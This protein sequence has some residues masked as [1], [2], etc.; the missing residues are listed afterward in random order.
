[1]AA[2]S[3][4][5]VLTYIDKEIELVTAE[6]DDVRRVVCVQHPV[7]GVSFCVI[8]QWK[9]VPFFNIHFVINTLAV[10]LF[11]EQKMCLNIILFV[12]RMQGIY[13]VLQCLTPVT[14]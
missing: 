4:L 9:T 7:V 3:I 8:C 11:Y 1:M 13:R 14:S 12:R 5:L 10:S 2:C 6:D